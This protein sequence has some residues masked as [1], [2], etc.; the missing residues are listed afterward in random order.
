MAD[1][2]SMT[3]EERRLIT[4][5]PM[6][7]AGNPAVIDGAV[8]FSVTS[9]TCT[10]QPLA[11]PEPTKA[12][13]VSGSEPG[14]SVVQMACDADIGSGVVP[15]LDTMLVHVTSASAASLQ[16]SVGPPELKQGG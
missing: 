8:Q 6:T 4:A 10:I 15:V 12:Y 1:A 2:I 16:V 5:Q 9:G 7:A 3:N 11:P 13:V 14:D